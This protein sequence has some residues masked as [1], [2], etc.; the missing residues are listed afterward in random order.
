MGLDMYLTRKKYIGAQYE[1][2]N[3]KGVIYITIG[4]KQIPIDFKKVGYIEEEVGYWRK[5]NAIHKWFVDNVQKRVDD[6]REYYVSLEKLKELLDI[7]EKVDKHHDKASELLPT[8]DGF[9]FGDTEYDEWYFK[10]IENTIKMLKDIIKEEEE[11]NEQH[12]YSDFYYSS[13]W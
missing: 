5:A 11:M 3:V 9:F 12:F 2:R 13:S 1:H 7:C 8:Q 6:C 4:E 10:D